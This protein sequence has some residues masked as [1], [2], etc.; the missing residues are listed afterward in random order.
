MFQTS[1]TGTNT[2]CNWIIDFLTKS[3]QSVTVD[4]VPS[5]ALL[6]NTGLP[7]ERVLSPLLHTLFI[8]DCLDLI[9]KYADG[10]PGFGLITN[11]E[12]HYRNGMV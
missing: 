1:P 11:D 10:T 5:S 2:L 8:Q 12:T 3:A 7:Q 6:I 4:D 9:V